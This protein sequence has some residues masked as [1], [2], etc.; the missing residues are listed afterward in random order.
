MATNEYT[1]DREL[2][3]ALELSRQSYEEESRKRR[4]SAYAQ[5]LIYW[6]DVEKNT[7]IQEIS[8]LNADIHSRYSTHSHIFPNGQGPHYADIPTTSRSVGFYPHIKD[9]GERENLHSLHYRLESDTLT[10]YLK[11]SHTLSDAQPNTSGT[12]YIEKWDVSPDAALKILPPSSIAVVV[13]FCSS[14]N[15]LQ[16][17]SDLIDLSDKE[18][19]FF[20]VNYQFE[21]SCTSC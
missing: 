16:T 18:V 19:I 20:L 3:L 13:P 21:I 11:T 17:N 12:S 14:I 15:S 1:Y 2:E 9:A 7:R 6:D 10:R 4:E 5:D 8:Q